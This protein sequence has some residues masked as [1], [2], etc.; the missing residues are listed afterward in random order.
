MPKNT[1]TVAIFGQRPENSIHLP[2]IPF[3]VRLNCKDGGIFI[4]GNE[5]KHRQTNPEDKIDISILKVAKFYGDLGKTKSAL[6]VQI[7]FV[8]APSVSPEILPP[9]TVC[10]TYIKKQSIAHLYNTVQAAM[11]HGDPGY[12][13]FTLTFNR[14]NGEKGVYYTI[15]FTWRERNNDAEKQQLAQIQNFLS[16]LGEQLIDIESTREMVSVDGVSA[17]ELQTIMANSIIPTETETTSNPPVNKQRQL[18]AAS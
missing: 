5:P 6:W 10:V 7:F 15:N 3:S 9:N 13:V 14:E 8:A 2:D 12:G 16:N 11:N 1:K 17:A 4:G 18:K